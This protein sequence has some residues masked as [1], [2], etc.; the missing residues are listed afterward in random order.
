MRSLG[1]KVNMQQTFWWRLLSLVPLLLWL[2]ASSARSEER[3]VRSVKLAADDWCPQ[4]CQG[5]VLKGYV[6]EVIEQALATQGATADITYLPWLRAIHEVKRGTYD[7][8]LTPTP[9]GYPEF[10]YHEEAVGYQ[11]YCFYTRKEASWRYTRE[12]DLLGQRLA[13][14]KDSGLGR[15]GTYLATHKGELSVQ[16]F[17]SSGDFARQI[18]KFLLSGRTDIIIMTSDVFL[19]SRKRALIP[20]AFRE[21]GCL[22]REKLAVGLAGTDPERAR[23]IA[24][25]L[26]EGIRELKKRGLLA[27]I[28][29][30]YGIAPW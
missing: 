4:H 5:D 21:A 17:V 3:P 20:D 8:L 14:L 22:G 27:A 24:R 13:Y 23:W 30:K 26:D 11:E 18:F 2:S 9:A 7:G 28:L 6:V 12:S 1:S 15:L 16:E 29:A 25:T 19:Y 10:V